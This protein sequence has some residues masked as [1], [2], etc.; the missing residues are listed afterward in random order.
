MIF[1]KYAA[2]AGAVAI[3]VLWPFA[4]GQIGQSQYEAE[5]EKAKSPYLAIENVSYDR[6]YLSSDVVTKFSLTGST[7]ALYEEEGLPTSFTVLSEV[8][9]G[10]LSIS[11]I[12]TLEMTPEVKTLS[13]VLWPSGESPITLVSETSIFGDTQFDLTVRAMNGG[14]EE[15]TITSSPANVSGTADKDGNMIYQLEMP[16]VELSGVEGEKFTFSE[17]TGSGQGKMVDEMW[18]GQ[19]LMNVK[20]TSLTDVTG[21]AATVTNL[22]INVQNEMDAT[23]GDVTTAK[24]E[25]LRITSKNTISF[26]KLDVPE[27]MVLDNF[28]LGVNFKDLDYTAMMALAEKADSLNAEPTDEEM[29]QLATYLDGLVESGM[30]FEL[31]PLEVDTPE[32]R[33]DAKFDLTV[34]PG[35]GSVTQNFGALMSKL[36][37]NLLVNVP[38]AYVHGVPAV[39]ASLSN[40]EPYG[41]ISEGENG[42]TL[43]AKIEGDQ[44]VSPTGERIPIGLL[45]MMF[46]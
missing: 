32:G 37:G 24:P 20:T 21:M 13:E 19:Q 1:G 8:G 44:A 11:S 17:I 25:E 27:T 36:K 41:F 35:L 7:K 3:A 12:S 43:E 40:L 15:V 2:V 16:S 14:D 33:V 28:K 26:Q 18:V 29:M 38:A 9:H 46:M 5:I 6:G 4:T 22:G 10:F 23:N 39:S 42:V 31:K 30:T 45:M 34:E